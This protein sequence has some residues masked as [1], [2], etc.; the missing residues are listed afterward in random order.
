MDIEFIYTIIVLDF[1]EEVIES[2]IKQDIGFKDNI[3][4]IFIGNGDEYKK[5]YPKNVMIISSLNDIGPEVVKGSYIYFTNSLK[6][7]KKDV[8]NI[9]KPNLDGNIIKIDNNLNEGN[10]NINDGFKHVFLDIGFTFIHHDL[11]SDFDNDNVDLFLNKSLIKFPEYKLVHLDLD[12]N[13]SINID[14]KLEMYSILNADSNEFTQYAIIQD[15]NDIILTDEYGSQY[16]NQIA[17]IL[18]SID[19][20]IIKKHDGIDKDVLKFMLYLKSNDFHH[21]IKGDK[22]YLKT[23]SNVVN[24]LHGHGIS[25]DMVDI[26][27]D[28]LYVS[29]IFKSSC[30]PDYLDFEAIVNYNDG[31]KEIFHASK[32]EYLKTGRG[33]VSYLGIDWRFSPCFDFEIPLDVKDNFKLE[34]V[35]RFHENGDEITLHPKVSLNSATCYISDYCNYI[36]KNSKIVIFNGNHIDVVDE[37]F[38]LKVRLELKLL[39]N[40]ITSGEKNAFYSI[41]IRILYYI[42]HPFWAR[43]RIWLFIDR[44]QMADDNAKHLFSYAL[45]QNDNVEKYYLLDK[46]CE[47]FKKMKQTSKNIVALDSIKHKLLYA[48]TEKFISSQTAKTFSNP[49]LDLNLK[50]FS[51][52]ATAERVFLQH[53]VTIHDVSHWFIKYA[54]NFVLLVTV[55]DIEKKAISYPHTNYSDDVIQTLGFPRYDNLSNENMEKQILFMPTWRKHITDEET[56]LKSDYYKMIKDFLNNEELLNFLDESG[57]KIMFKPHFEMSKYFHLINIPA[58]VELCNDIPY[59]ELFNKSML[60]ITDYSSVFFDFAYL[61]KPVIYYRAGDEYHNKSGYFDFEKMGFGEIITSKDDLINKIK[62]YHMNNFK[63]EAKYAKRVDEFFYY[64]DK[65]NCKR[66]YDCLYEIK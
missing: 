16:K 53:G 40:V 12:Q 46:N 65:N 5:K 50:L 23:G 48:Y 14:D 32:Y 31:R 38:L 61:K 19:E 4:L 36:V 55:S 33:R 6:P 29:G 30:H 24:G 47:D 44:P 60:L 34:F 62:D 21:K 54:Y 18:Q 56:F 37:S 63:M 28:K 41:F 35:I 57:F 7:F 66:V 9:L 2:I 11:I 49:Y 58:Q 43:K 42:M 1:K 8:F 52:L 26:I 64:T 15:L 45:N 20:K 27:N 13:K 51:N 3:Q 22:L 59:Q 39:F 17:N 25:L 10:Y